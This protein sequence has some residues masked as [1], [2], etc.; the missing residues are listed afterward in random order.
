MAK[1]VAIS[2]RITISKAQQNMILAVAAT[3]LVVGVSLAF[4]IHSFQAIEF[5]ARVIMGKDEAIVAYSN[6]IKDVGICKK[7]KGEVY[8]LEELKRCNP[9]LIKADDV[10]GTLRYNIINNLAYDDAL[11]AVAGNTNSRCVDNKTGKPYT[12]K[13]LSENYDAVKDSEDEEKIS[14]AVG[15]IKQCSALRLIPDALP[16][17]G[18]DEALLSS[19]NKIF[20]ISDWP[21][22]SLSPTGSSSENGMDG[23]NSIMVNLSMQTDAEVVYRVLDNVEHSIREFNI[24]RATIESGYDSEGKPTL[25]LRANA[26]AYWIDPVELNEKTKTIPV[27]KN[28]K[29]GSKK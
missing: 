15:L 19:L 10:P 18:N 11:A 9:D 21:P 1:E 28:T 20:Q 7:P 24:E 17:R 5:N 16:S 13:F 12:L 6:T 23:L 14:S 29:K 3:G 27:D 26:A 25:D 22:E 8:T 2:K 4:L